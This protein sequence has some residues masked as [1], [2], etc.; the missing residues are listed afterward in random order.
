[1]VGRVPVE[2]FAVPDPGLLEVA[3][4][5]RLDRGAVLGRAEV[6]DRVHVVVG[7]QRRD[8][9]LSP[10]GH[11]VDDASGQVARFE[12]LVEV[13][14]RKRVLLGRNRDDGV[15]HRDRRGDEAD[16][17]EQRGLVRANDADRPYGLGQRERHVAQRCVVDRAIP[18]VGHRRIR[19]QPLDAGGH[20]GLARHARH[21]GNAVG[22]FTFA[23]RQIL[24]DEVQHLRAVVR[25]RVCPPRSRP[26]R[27]DR[28]ADVLAVALSDIADARARGVEHRAAVPSVGTDLLAADEQLGRA[29]DRRDPVAARGRTGARR[30]GPLGRRDGAP[31][32]V[33][34]ESLPATLTP[35]AAL[36]EAAKA[37]RGVEQVG[38]VD[39]H[40]TRFDLTRDIERQVQVVAPDACRQA[41]PGVVGQ[42][43]RLGRG[44][45]R[46]RHQDRTEDLDLRHRG[47]RLD[48]GQQRRRIEVPLRRAGP[49]WLPQRRALV[50]A[51]LDQVFD[52]LQ[53]AGRDDRADV[54]G[55]VERVADAQLL[56]PRAQLGQQRL[57]DVL[58]DQQAR[59]GAAHLPLVEPDRVHDAFD[60]A[61]QVGA[62]EHDER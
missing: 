30:L 26:G 52:L 32:Y 46:H 42:R 61:V 2:G 4:R 39:P 49:R 14:H 29:I 27:L 62:V 33:F 48:T 38:A 21:Q 47:R 18:F 41:E 40:D 37:R 55:L 12:H 6:P 58:L 15:A 34:V 7:G 56:H 25:R 20:L 22:E 23:C 3:D 5:G 43:H 50:D 17:P 8:D 10:A 1:M 45:E 44:T 19:E 51:L 35:V 60:H 13:G 24:G 16:E 59:A 53:L 31:A 36:A 57:G 54:D 11:D 28:V 9:V